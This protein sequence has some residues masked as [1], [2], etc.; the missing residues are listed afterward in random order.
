V[1]V[2]DIREVTDI[3]VDR[4]AADDLAGELDWWRELLLK[5]QEPPSLD[6]L[7]E[8]AELLKDAS[9]ILIE[10]GR[11]TG[12]PCRMCWGDKELMTITDDLTDMRGVTC[13]ACDGSGLGNWP[14]RPHVSE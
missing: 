13:V 2:V 11:G 1:A 3:P 10:F 14:T 4:S 5:V 8:L 9:D 12:Y 7:E 6:R